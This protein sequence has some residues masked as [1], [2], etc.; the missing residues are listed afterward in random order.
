MNKEQFFDEVLEAV[1][2][3]IPQVLRDEIEVSVREVIKTNDEVL[4]GISVMLPDTNC[5]P[6]IYLEE[7]YEDYMNGMQID[8]IAENII[9]TSIAAYKN[10]PSI[11]EFALEYEDIQDKLTVQVVDGDM[12]KGRLKDLIYQ[13]VGNGFVAIPYIVVRE[14]EHGRMMAAVTKPMAKEMEYDVD[15][16]LET[17]FLN[18]AERNEPVFLGMGGMLFG[19]DRPEVVN[20]MKDGF[21]VDN[22]LGM[23]VLT[24]TSQQNGASVLFYP[25]MQKRIGEVLDKNYYVLPSSLHEVI[26]VPEGTG[27][28]LKELQAM[29]KDANRTVV[30]SK[31]VLSDKVLFYDRERDRLI[32]PK[33]KERDGEERSDR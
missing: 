3:Q 32:E 9:G 1:K 13:P 30:D 6:T 7:C 4:H 20:P 31:E 11:E 15:K 27:P 8:E 33:V 2:N 22:N 14:D 26:I 16:L 12:N 23:Y 28:T 29:V 17:A 25:D 5:A 21:A 19:E 24:N 18:T 10:A